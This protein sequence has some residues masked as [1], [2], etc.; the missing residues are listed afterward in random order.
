MLSTRHE[1]FYQVAMNLSF[2][3]AS[4]VL[5]IS[6]PAISKHIKALE[7]YYKIPLFE[8]K[9]NTI[10]LTEGGKFLYNQ[11]KEA[12]RIESLVEY[13]L[14]VIHNKANAKGDLNLGASTTV[15]LYFLPKILSKF[16]HEFSNI[17]INLLNRNTDT[18]IQAL[19]NEA[20]DIGIVEGRKKNTALIYKPFLSDEVVAVCSKNSFIANKKSIKIKEIVDLPIVLREQGSG[21]LEA[22]KE[23]LK[24]HGIKLSDLKV[25]VR[26]SG[27]EALKNFLKEDTCLGF[28]P[29]GAITREIETGELHVVKIEGL[30]IFRNFYF[31][32][33]R[34]TERNDINKVF[35]QFCENLV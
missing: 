6:Q 20:I 8:R 13:E 14:S 22:L 31:V 35:I 16:H 3:K 29:K 7:G 30:K 10:N 5:F 1:V 18:I 34:D 24:P 21:T 23:N 28:L 12:K 11:I 33:R 27:T 25:S 4:Q 17:H 32:Q 9:R 15:A 26:L 19:L 2:S